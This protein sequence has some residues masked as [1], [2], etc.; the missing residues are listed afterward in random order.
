MSLERMLQITLAALLTLGTLLLG[1]GQ[2]SVLLPLLAAV[3]AVGSVWLTD[4]QGR[5]QL[6]HYMATLLALGTLGI[7]ALDL[8][9]LGRDNQLLAIAN[10]LVYLQVVLQFQRKDMRIYWQL[11]MLSLLQVVVAAALSLSPWFGPLILLY[12]FLGLLALALFFAFRESQRFGL[13]R[14]GLSSRSRET[15]GVEILKSRD[16]GYAEG[17]WP[18]SRE[19]L[20]QGGI[21]R[22]L[23]RHVTWHGLATLL[24]ATAL[25]FII[26]RFQKTPLITHALA[27]QTM[28]G[29]NETVTLGQL[30]EALQDRSSVMRVW[31]S[32][33][34]TGQPYS[35]A[36]EPLFRGAIVDTYQNEKWSLNQNDPLVREPHELRDA[37]VAGNYVLQRFALEE[38]RESTAFSILPAYRVDS[39]CPIEVDPRRQ[40]LIRKTRRGRLEFTLATTGLVGGR[41][42]EIVPASN[43]LTRDERARLLELPEL[44]AQGRDP[45]RRLKQFAT[46]AAGSVPEANRRERA[47]ALEAALGPSQG[48]EYSLGSVQRDPQNDLVEDFVAVNKRGHCEYFASALTLMLRSQGI[49]A[50]MV[51]GF[52]G[53]EF[54]S[55]GNYYQVRMLHAHT[56]VEAYLEPEQVPSGMKRR[57]AGG[58]LKLDPTPGSNDSA[59]NRTL[60][61][62]EK[63]RDWMDYGDYLWMNYVVGLDQRRQQEAVFAPLSVGGYSLGDLF[64]RRFWTRTV[65][66]FFR[67]LRKVET[68]KSFARNLM[69]GGVVRAG[70]LL[71]AGYLAWRYRRFGIKLAKILFNF[72]P[73]RPRD[74]KPRAARKQ[75]AVPFYERL[76][77]LLAQHGIR[78]PESQ[79]QHEFA[80]AAGGQLSETPRLAPAA[81]LPRRV[82]DAF[83]RVRFGN[84]A[85]DKAEIEAVE[86]SLRELEATLAVAQ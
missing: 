79:T 1:I 23:A 9:R 80:V 12:L 70:A 10:L 42:V 31:F 48:F 67:S 57:S 24:M 27:T 8:L 29:Y 66:Q 11:L 30:G 4:V 78:R 62:A 25:F 7:F 68:W 33:S 35:V 43:A 74:R 41:Q 47:R 76:E 59:E 21:G 22:D 64:N 81:G 14:Y 56:W 32:D 49:P 77:A 71:I 60:T 18:V 46:A 65:P 44:D 6:K 83:Y 15:S 45:L 36:E 54:N 55:L 13:Q 17:F 82:V 63:A 61:L 40:Q 16:S 37:P 69:E 28:I 34:R 53:G 86:L 20:A 75:M 72:V 2:G 58:W 73:L 50:R 39:S 19:D 26:P 51:I 38:Q 52:K 84:H 85:L 5:V 3:A